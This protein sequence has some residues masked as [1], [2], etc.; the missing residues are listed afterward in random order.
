MNRMSRLAALGLSLAIAGQVYTEQQNRVDYGAVEGRVINEKGLP[1]PGARVY[2]APLGSPDPG[3][4][5]HTLSG[6]G[7]TFLFPN[8]IAGTNILMAGKEE[9]GY[10]NSLYA[11]FV[12]NPSAL[13]R[14]VVTPGKDSRGIVITLRDCANL[15]GRVV[16]FDTGEGI[17]GAQIRLARVD[18]PFLD[19]RTSPDINGNFE[20][21]LPD[22]PYLLEIT[23]PGYGSWQRSGI[24][25]KPHSALKVNARL[26]K[27]RT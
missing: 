22:L 7:G 24:L 3:K 6:E 21:V 8:A 23:A 9:E 18:D 2:I 20:F 14:V 13:P 17:S 4:L 26:K 25:L 16:D 27:A 10:C 1:V 19:V 5:M 12:A 15:S 11:P